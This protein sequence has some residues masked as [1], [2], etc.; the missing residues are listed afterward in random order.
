MNL[1]FRPAL[2]SDALL[3]HTLAN[4]IWHEHYP[5]IIS[6]E[7]INF[8]LSDRY[9]Q[10]AILNG[11]KTGESFFLAFVGEEAVAYAS[12]EL[13]KDSLFLSKFYVDVSKHRQGIGMKFLDYI[14]S[15]TDSTLP[16]RLQVNR[17]NIK[18]INFY[19]KAGFTIEKAAD[20]DIG[21]GFFMNDFVMVRK[22][23]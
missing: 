12:V 4:K 5:S 10:E 15:Q 6:R 8:M 11:M 19:F 20:F 3:I 13:Q 23:T 1:S 21:S 16:M 18:A 9:S 2:D 17:Q 7:Q 14:L 22:G